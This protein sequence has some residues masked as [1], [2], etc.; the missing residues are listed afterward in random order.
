MEFAGRAGLDVVIHPGVG[1]YPHLQRP[2]L[3]VE[4]IRAAFRR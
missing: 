4:E 3:A 1:H 2:E